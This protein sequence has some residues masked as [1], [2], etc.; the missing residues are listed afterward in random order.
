MNLIIDIGNTRVKL[1]VFK[2]NRLLEKSVETKN[3]IEK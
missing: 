2:A 1:A 3:F